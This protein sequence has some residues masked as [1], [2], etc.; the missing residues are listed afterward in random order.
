MATHPYTYVSHSTAE[1]ITVRLIPLDN[2][3]SVYPTNG[4]ELVDS[5]I[6]VRLSLKKCIKL[7]NF[8]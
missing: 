8:Y 4:Y 6:P 3:Y 7:I 5:G 2:C 1:A